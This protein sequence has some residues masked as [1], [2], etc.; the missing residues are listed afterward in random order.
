MIDLL[1]GIQMMTLAEDTFGT[2]DDP[3]QMPVTQ[4]SAEKLNLLTPDW[5]AYKVDPTGKL[6]AFAVV[7]PT[8]R[9]IAERF[10]AG[11]ITER[12]ILELTTPQERYSALYLCSAITVP[13]YQRQGLAT[14]LFKELIAGIS[15][16]DDALL[17]AW[18][19]NE[20]GTALAKRLESDLGKE[21]KIR[22]RHE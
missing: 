20:G 18:T 14:D 19:F 16:T 15:L 12:E 21:I 2:R 17:F 3:D 6:K 10:L 13:E 11:E 7:T 9:E 22:E 1:V 4:E 8:T 5:L